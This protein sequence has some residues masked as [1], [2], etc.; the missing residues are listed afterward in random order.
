[1]SLLAAV[2]GTGDGGGGLGDKFA[3]SEEAA[4]ETE[5]F[6][7]VAAGAVMRGG[8]ALSRAA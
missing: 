1:M 3:G 7:G 6:A 2:E 8:A 4:F 5:A